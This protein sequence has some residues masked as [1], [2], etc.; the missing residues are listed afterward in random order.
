[1][2]NKVGDAI[3][4]SWVFLFIFSFGGYA[5]IGIFWIVKEIGCR[6]N[7]S[8]ENYMAG[9][10]FVHTL[11]AAWAHFYKKQKGARFGV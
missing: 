6:C 8:E 5:A 11:L 9:V 1:L 2:T 10:F 3:F 4:F 7:S